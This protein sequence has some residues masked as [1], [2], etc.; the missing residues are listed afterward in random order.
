MRKLPYLFF[1][2]WS[3]RL[4]LTS[5]TEKTVDR[6]QA[7]GEPVH[8]KIPFLSG[9]F[10]LYILYSTFIVIFAG[11]MSGLTVGYTSIDP[12]MLAIKLRNGTPEEMKS[13]AR[14]KPIIE[15]KHLLLATLLTAN[16]LAMESLPIF[17]DAIMPAAAAVLVSTSIVLVF[18]EVVPQALCLGPNQIQIAAGMAPVVKWLILLFYPICYPIS[19]GLDYFLG[20]HQDKIKFAKKDLK[21]LMELHMRTNKKRKTSMN[22][23]DK[24]PNATFTDDDD[25]L[26]NEEIKIINNTIDLRTTF[27]DSIMIPYDNMFKLSVNDVISKELIDRVTRKGFNKIP[28]FTEDLHCIGILSI[29]NLLSY[30]SN[31]G[32]TIAESKIKLVKP[33][34]IVSNTNLLEALSLMQ[35]KKTNILMVSKEVKTNRVSLMLRSRT[36][37]LIDH[38]KSNVVGMVCLKDIFEDIAQEEFDD[39]EPGQINS[40]AHEG[41]PEKSPGTKAVPTNEAVEMEYTG[42]KEK[43]LQK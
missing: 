20:H 13:S 39:S 12:R 3:V 24:A 35:V 21:T 41:K 25:G 16:A 28:I 5:E 29:K 6:S 26:T 17:L 38:K 43:L 23:Q 18:G 27:V 42:K 14:I 36:E 15:D 8:Q 10:F 33:F 40:G 11:L 9:E 31:L 30:S 2:M 7:I 32:K 37:M 19:K 34:T 22:L 1:F 4:L